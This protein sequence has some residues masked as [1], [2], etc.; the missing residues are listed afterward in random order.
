MPSTRQPDPFEEMR[1]AAA[2]VL[3]GLDRLRAAATDSADLAPHAEA[4]RLIH[5]HADR[6]RSI[7]GALGELLG[8]LATSLTESELDD[9]QTASEY[10]DDAAGTV[11]GTAA[12]HVDRART[13]IAPHLP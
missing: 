10:L 2:I 4:L 5:D 12:K 11:E 3:M 6:D 13:L 1:T 9:V 8:T 7:L